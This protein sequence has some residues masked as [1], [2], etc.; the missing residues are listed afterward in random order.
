MNPFGSLM[1]ADDALDLI[2][3]KLKPVADSEKVTLQECLGRVLAEDVKSA[4]N[5]PA[6]DRA[7]MDGYAVIAHD[8]NE[9]RMLREVGKAFAGKPYTK[10]LNNLEC[11]EIATGAQLPKGADA[12]VMVEHATV[13]G[14]A[15][16]FK[17]PIRVGDNVGR[18]AEDIAKGDTVIKKGTI[19]G[20]GQ[21]AALAIV[22]RDKVEVYRRPSV[23][24]FTTGDEVVAPGKKLGAGQVYDCNSSAMMAVAQRAGAVV[25]WRANVKD[26]ADSL[27]KVLKDNARKFDAIVFSGGTSV[28]N[29][30]FGFETVNKLGDVFVRGVAIKPGKPVLFGKI[31]NCAVFGMPGYP[32]SCLLTAELFLAPGIRKLAHIEDHHRGRYMVKLAHEVK[33]DKTKQVLLPVR[34]DEHDNAYSTFKGSGSI[35]SLSDSIGYIKVEPG[36]GVMTKGSTAVVHSI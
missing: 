27:L 1:S 11:V 2:Q 16:S 3:A 24:L 17:Q 32:T 4:V 34:V 10:K 28:G 29:K 18:T 12:V 23:L 13:V 14:S 20:P 36:D 5:V 25:T 35:T 7:S 8:L 19:L 26:L 9:P 15:I 33:Q 30:D 31:G 21:I 22:G 6:F